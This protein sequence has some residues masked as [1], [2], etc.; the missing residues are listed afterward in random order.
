MHSRR[1]RAFT[2][3]E[4][5]IV[6]AIVALFSAVVLNHLNATRSENRD[7]K[8]IA[9]IEDITQALKLFFE[10]YGG[11]PAVLSPQTLVETGFL[12]EVPKPPAGVPNKEYLYSALNRGC[13]SYHLGTYLENSDLSVFARDADAESSSSIGVDCPQVHGAPSTS[14]EDFS[15]LGPVFDIKP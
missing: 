2:L 3:T 10:A 13:T 4:L 14:T 7:Q 5:L 8:R 12:I 6:V 11:Y 1:S 15:G 9:D